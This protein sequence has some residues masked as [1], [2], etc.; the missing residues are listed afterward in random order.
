MTTRGALILGR[1][2]VDLDDPQ[3]GG[4]NTAPTRLQAPDDLRLGEP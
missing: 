4:H 3:I 2:A 1:A